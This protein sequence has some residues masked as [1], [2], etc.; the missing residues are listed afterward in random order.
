MT[1]ASSDPPEV[2]GGPVSIRRV[3]VLSVSALAVL[4]AEPLYLL[5]DLGVVGRLGALPLAGLGVGTLVL[6]VVSTQ[7]TFLSYGTTARSARR[8]GAGDRAGAVAEGLQA[9]W[10]AILVGGAVVAVV[11]VAA[12]TILGALAGDHQTAAAATSWLRIAVCGVPLILLSMAGN[13]WLRGIQDTRAPIV[14]VTVGLTISAVLC[15]VLVHGLLGAPRLELPGSAVANLVGQSVSGAAFAV[16]VLRENS[17]GLRPR[18]AVILAQLTMARDLVLRSLSFQA[19]FLSAAAVASRF[20]VASVAAHQL[21]LQ[22]W[23]FVSLV[24]DSL[25][26]AAQSLVGAAIGAGS[27]RTARRVARTVTIGSV[28][29]ASV[30]MLIFV[31]GHAGIPRLF[32]TDGA[33]L[34]QAGVP[35]WFF[36]AMLPVAGVVFAL[37]GVLLGGGDAAFLRTATLGAALLGFLPLIWLSYAYG[38]G[39]A[40]I[41]TGLLT[42][43]VLRLLTLVFRI[44]GD[45][46]T[47]VPIA[48]DSSPTNSSGTVGDQ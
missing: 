28:T 34:A 9:S 35:M 23:N 39:L 10:I 21:V 20:G 3:T 45:G 25:A 13:G 29:V 24:L 46:W 44:R 41:W 17:R 4:V 33:V 48:V 30:L 37:D 6:G 8:F 27:A 36:A 38:W 43:M 12:P 7:L 14:Y 2:A 1:T 42:F 47:E 31:V 16:R 15:P 11:E 5:L 19:C 22:L 18:P 40:G 26:I 32:T